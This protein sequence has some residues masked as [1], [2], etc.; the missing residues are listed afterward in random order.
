MKHSLC[1]ATSTLAIFC[2]A[3]QALSQ[4]TF[5]TDDFTVTSN[6]QNVNQ[7]LEL[8]QT[9]SLAPFTYTPM[10][11]QTQVG[12]P[13]T[14][15][16]QPGGAS[17]SNYLLLA[18][19]S[20]FHSD[21]DIDASLAQG[22][23]LTIAFDMYVS[24]NP[25]GDATDKWG[26]FTLRAPGDGWPVAGAGEFGMLMRNDGRIEMFQNA[27]SAN[28]AWNVN[29][30]SSDPRWELTFSD[31]AGTG[32]AFDGNGSLLTFT[33]GDNTESVALNQL[34]STGLRLGFRNLDAMFIG[35]DNLEIRVVPEPIS[36]MLLGIGLIV[37]V[38][39]LRERQC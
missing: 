13:E 32:S 15:V 6:T 9:G 10:G 37:G 33:N 5:L 1:L 25:Q 36:G 7:E 22:G 4:E 28:P 12:N 20:S 8:R 26:A 2:T 16:G 23:P 18:F 21:L 24:G 39:W 31:T 11:T 30:Y 29:G 17:N 35:I 27:D 14:D 3:N 19:N 34:S 38:L